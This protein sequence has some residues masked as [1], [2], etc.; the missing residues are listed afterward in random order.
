MAAA[1]EQMVA[2]GGEDRCKELVDYNRDPN[3]ERLLGAILLMISAWTAGGLMIVMGLT[4]VVG[5]IAAC[6]MFGLVPFGGV[7][8]ILPSQGRRL[9]WSLVGAIGKSVVI[10]VGIGGALSITMLS[11]TSVAEV[12]EDVTMIERFALVNLVIMIAFTMRRRVIASGETL[13]SRMKDYMS[14]PRGSGHDWTNTT[15]GSGGG[16]D[17]GESPLMAADRAVG[18]VGY[19][20]AAG[21]AYAAAGGSVMAG[22][23]LIKRM[24]ERRVARR[25]Y[26]NLQKISL[27][28]RTRN[29]QARIRRWRAWGQPLP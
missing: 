4:I 25:S 1:G 17:D 27:W 23:F 13:A 14:A 21:P 7:L 2:E 10:V 9:A 16:G 26:K 18:M 6:L 3:G 8:V 11:L 29:N 28:K 12:A 5:K 15:A 24:E 20:A 22:R 19:G